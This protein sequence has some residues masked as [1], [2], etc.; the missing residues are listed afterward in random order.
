MNELKERLVALGMS[1]E[2]ADQA[3]ATAT[4]YV[5]SK[6]PAGFHPMIDEVLAGK[7]PDIGGAF[8]ALGGLFGGK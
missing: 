3:I 1:G 7:S 6:T 5:K 2:L 4:D 8:G